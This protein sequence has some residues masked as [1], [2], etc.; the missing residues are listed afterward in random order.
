MQTSLNITSVDANNKKVTKSLT[1]IN[2]S[3][4]NAQLKT[5]A[6]KFNAISQNTY[7]EAD[8]IIK[9]SVEE[10]YG[11]K[12]EPTLT[13]SEFTYTNSGFDGYTGFEAVITY[14]GDGTLTA[15]SDK[16]TAVYTS[17]DEKR[18]YI[19]AGNE[20]ETFSGT[21]SSSAGTTYAAKSI[22]FSKE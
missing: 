5:A 16:M 1:Y 11:E 9:M 20:S 13:I 4:T 15:V 21:L 7:S 6:Q 14:N 12:I 10:P 17:N 18:L 8:R 3:A 2:K 22:T 19:K